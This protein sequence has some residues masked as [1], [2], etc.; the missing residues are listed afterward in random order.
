MDSELRKGLEKVL[1]NFLE[2]LQGVQKLLQM[3]LSKSSMT[4]RT[5]SVASPA[6][7]GRPP[8]E[9]IPNGVPRPLPCQLSGNSLLLPQPRQPQL[10]S[11]IYR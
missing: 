5:S 2:A 1:N 9:K 6:L 4:P 11:S 3:T 10:D 8:L 7:N